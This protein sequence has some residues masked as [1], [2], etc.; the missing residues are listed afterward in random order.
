[1]K[2]SHTLPSPGAGFTLIEL[3]LVVVIIGILAS[4]V[5]PN[6]MGHGEKARIAAAQAQLA[7]LRAALGH[8]ELDM[9]SFPS[10]D[11]GLEALVASPPTVGRENRWKGPYLAAETGEVPRDPW[12]N[13]Y[14]YACPGVRSRLGYDLS[15]AGPDGQPGTAD[16]IVR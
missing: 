16:D 7:I 6:L 9:G 12:G 4:V 8:Y 2:R 10:T 13:L 5:L 11:P 15:S 1:M 14:L 3:L